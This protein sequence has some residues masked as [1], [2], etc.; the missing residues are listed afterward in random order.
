MKL[1]R[2]IQ[3]SRGRKIFFASAATLAAAMVGT[4]LYARLVAPRRY[5]LDSVR[6]DTL[7]ASDG[8]STVRRLRILHLSDLHLSAPETHK[9]DFLARVTDSQFDLIVITGD[10][11]EDLSALQYARKIISRPPRLGA[12]AVLGNH[13]CYAYNIFHRTV[14][15]I[16]RKWRFPGQF[17]DVSPIVGALEA[18][19]IQVLRN[20]T[21]RIPAEQLHIIGVDY[22][23]VADSEFFRLAGQ[24][25]TGDLVLALMHI[26]GRLAR[27]EKAGVHLA[28]AGHTHG[29]QVCLPFFGPLITDSEL[30]RHEA[31]GLIWRGNSAIHVSRGLG[32]DSRTNIRLFCP[33]HASIIEVCHRPGPAASQ[34]LPLEV[35]CGRVLNSR[36]ESG[37]P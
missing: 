35:L 18:A 30:P 33:P 29:G 7:F 17:R 3:G 1:D 28:F 10:I 2:F 26:P 21:A 8:E 36:T 19:G 31:S 25:K 22:P 15:R 6:V 9:L 4:F 11:F 37:Q 32:A 12:F 20:S 14:G 34:V 24:A 23:G 16:L 13:D 27:L 5:R